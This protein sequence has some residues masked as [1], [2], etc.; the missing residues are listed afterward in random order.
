MKDDNDFPRLTP[1][2]DRYPAHDGLLRKPEELTDDQFDLLAAAWAGESLEGDS[3]VE[4]NSVISAIPSRRMRAESFSKLKLTPYNDSWVYRN[5]LLK[6]FPATKTIRRTLVITLL[7]VAAVIAIIIT[8]PAIRNR[9][10]DTLPGAIPEG[11]VMSEAL[12]HEAYPVIIPESVKVNPTGSREVKGAERQ[13][14]TRAGDIT[15]PRQTLHTAGINVSEKITLTAETA[16]PQRALPVS[17]AIDAVNPVMIAS[18]KTT[19]LHAMQ[20]ADII[21]TAAEEKADNW[22]VRGIS[23]LA[24]TVT[25]EEKN[26]DGYVIASACVNGIN[27]VLGWEMQLRQSNNKAGETVAVN[28]SSSLLSFTA[29]VNKNSP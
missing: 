1:P 14:A 8:I 26:I 10:T 17:L 6:E 18:A 2:E 4:F 20:M 22:I 7:S 16:E 11:A 19:D 23:L 21:P 28:F 29:P 12:I 24:K 3:L 25:K 13:A 9:T 5:N 27:N 15:E